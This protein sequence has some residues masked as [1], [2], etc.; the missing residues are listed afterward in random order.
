MP[1]VIFDNEVSDA[2]LAQYNLIVMGLPSKLSIMNE[3]NDALPIP[4]D[5]GT[6]I[7]KKNYS[8]VTYLIP[9]DTPLGYVQLL[10]SP[11]NENNIAI[12]A[13]G[14]TEQGVIKAASALFD[15]TLRGQLAG[16]FAA[17]NG[18]Q[19]QTVDTRVGLPVAEPAVTPDVVDPLIP[20]PIQA[21]LTPPVVSRPVWLLIAIQVI[22]GLIL[23]IVLLIFWNQ[24]RR[25]RI[26]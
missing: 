19:V 23:I 25:S 20:Q 3:L 22:I 18:T 14:N 13:L 7:A 1:K 17:I 2:E 15:P 26:K 6:N 11:W 4:F 10:Q 24:W 21:D 16:N 5:L 12:V 8:Q 9:S